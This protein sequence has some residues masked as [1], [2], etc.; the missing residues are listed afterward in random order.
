VSAG[1]RRRVR[2]TALAAIVAGVVSACSAPAGTPDDRGG[3]TGGSTAAGAS[4]TTARSAPTTAAPTTAAPTGTASSGTP[5]P[6]PS[7]PSQPSARRCAQ[8]LVADMSASEQAG[9]LLMV[10][11]DVNAR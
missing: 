3:V 1:V 10:G 5:Y 9:Q 11:L 4:S 7:T 8:T 6:T 2:L